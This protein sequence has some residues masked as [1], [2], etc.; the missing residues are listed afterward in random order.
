VQ[1]YSGL[2]YRG[3]RIVRELTGGLA[4]SLRSRALSVPN[5]VGTAQPAS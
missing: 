1:V 3:P 2:I 5:V 4:K